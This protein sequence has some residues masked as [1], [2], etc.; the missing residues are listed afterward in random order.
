[1]TETKRIAVELGVEEIP[2]RMMED[3][4]EELEG[5]TGDWQTD[6]RLPEGSLQALG[7]PR[8]LV[9]TGNLQAEQETETTTEKGPPVDVAFEDGE[10]TRALEGFCQQ[11]GVDPGAVETEV[12]D[13]GEYVVLE[14]TIEGRPVEAVLEESFAE[15][16]TGL[17][18]PKSM[19]WESSGTSFI[20][21]IRWIVAFCED[22]AL[23]L[24]VGPVD[25]STETRGMRF[26]EN[27]RLRV[28]GFDDYHS[29]IR[30]ETNIILDQNERRTTIRDAAGD[31]AA[32]KNG[33]PVYDEDL[34]DEVTHLVE[35]P[36]PF[37]GSF[38]ERFLDVPDAVL[39]ESMQSHQ[40][41]FPVENEEGLLPYFIGVRNGGE[42]HLETVVEGNEKVLRA[43]L[44]DAEFFYNK[45]L[46][47]DYEAFRDELDGVVFQE[48][49]GS[50]KDK[51]DR[52]VDLVDELYD[53]DEKEFLLKAAR[54]CKNDLVTDMVEEFPKLQGTMGK[55]YAR[56][57]GWDERTAGLIEEHY[58]PKGR[59]DPLPGGGEDD[60]AASL[61]A[62]V[63][64]LDTIVG[65]FGLGKRATGS[66]DPFGLRRDALG[67]LRLLLLE[68]LEGR[69]FDLRNLLDLTAKNYAEG[70]FEINPDDRE[71]LEAFF[72]DRL[73]NYFTESYSHEILSSTI[74]VLWNR[75]SEA[76]QRM[77]WIRD[78]RKESQ[79]QDVLTAY[80]RPSNILDGEEIHGEVDPELFE[81][82]TENILFEASENASDALEDALEDDN[83]DAVL[84]TLA[85]LRMP[86]DDF[87]ESVM[88]MAE[89]DAVRQNRLLLLDGVKNIF[90][91]VADFS[92]FE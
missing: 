24:T 5:R 49:L 60:F 34:L 76:E 16:F 64:R 88:V 43:R 28:E 39:I 84:S 32:E 17:D 44:N 72:Q 83:A 91:R 79:F 46:E 57:S 25:S 21:P 45:D 59:F 87:F 22:R 23:D 30:E 8:R 89:D 9:L 33:E 74:P 54:H 63:D 66:S 55:I 73:F 26:T 18:W 14:K 58:K 85:G 19:R 37:R 81:D 62:L 35:A 77:E 90:D 70:D 67:I 29:T 20:R 15:V 12:L 52:L 27:E 92:V 2:A 71:D 56:E 65:F 3:A 48:E 41:Y 61:L 7:T 75:P 6:N 50:L 1:M 82:E 51:T 10:P 69:A 31:L 78:W 13:G 68:S 40:W 80:E 4:L 38:E 36:T 53:G 42:E 11:H 47:T 86:V